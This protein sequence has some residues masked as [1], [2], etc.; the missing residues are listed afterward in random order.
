MIFRDQIELRS[1]SL[2]YFELVCMIACNP[3]ND[4]SSDSCVGEKYYI[5]TLSD[6]FCLK[7]DRISLNIS[8]N[9]TP[10]VAD[11]SMATA[12][13]LL[14]RNQVTRVT[15]DFVRRHDENYVE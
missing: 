11:S 12:I 14:L 7:C 6:H 2:P 4:T 1:Q 15:Q 3:A 5:H 10:T 8:K 13:Y 9:M